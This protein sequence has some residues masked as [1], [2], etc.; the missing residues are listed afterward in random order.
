MKIRSDNAARA[1]TPRLTRSQT[2][3]ARQRILDGERASAVAARLGIGR[4]T[5]YRMFKRYNIA[6]PTALNPHLASEHIR[7]GVAAARARGVTFHRPYALTREEAIDAHWRLVE[8]ESI[9]SV[10]RA[11]GV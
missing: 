10:A 7:T 3:G 4:T 9:R 11:F 6:T 5:L 1:P 8:G 2:L